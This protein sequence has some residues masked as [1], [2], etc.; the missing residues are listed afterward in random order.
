MD[1]PYETNSARNIAP[2]REFPPQRSFPMTDRN[3]ERTERNYVREPGPQ[4]DPALRE[5]PAGA[6]RT[7]I[8]T[9]VIAA[10]VLAVMYGITAQ[11]E[12]RND[13]P[14]ITTGSNQTP[15]QTGGRTTDNAPPNPPVT[16][17]APKSGG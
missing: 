1:V 10:A 4:P 6:A 15:S 11:R 8:V 7:W 16:T 17:P 3:Q 12:A 13:G 14:P 5:G 2:P 9:G